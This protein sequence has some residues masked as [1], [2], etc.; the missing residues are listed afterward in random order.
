MGDYLKW[1]SQEAAVA[2]SKTSQL[3]N[4]ETLGLSNAR[5]QQVF[6]GFVALLQVR[7]LCSEALTNRQDDLNEAAAQSTDHRSDHEHKHHTRSVLCA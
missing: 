4:K 2:L 3:G 5:L 6:S 1:P 7:Q